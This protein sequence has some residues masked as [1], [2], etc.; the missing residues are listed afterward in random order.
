MKP[1]SFFLVINLIFFLVPSQNPFSLP[2]YNYMNYQ[3]KPFNTRANAIEAA[4][5]KLRISKLTEKELATA[6]NEKMRSNSK[7][8]IALFIPF[9]AIIFALVFIDRRRRFGEHFVFATHLMTFL[10]CLFIIQKI[11]VSLFYFAYREE[12]SDVMVSATEGLIFLIYLSFAINRFYV[13]NWWRPILSSFV[14]VFLLVIVMQAYRIF[15]FY[16]VLNAI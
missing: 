6:F 10:I 15:L 12:I 11:I 14:I 2:F 8:F 13:K 1:F 4:R 5:A 7:V 3:Y 9:F 16:Q